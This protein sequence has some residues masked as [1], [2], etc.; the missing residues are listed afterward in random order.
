MAQFFIGD[1]HGCAT[2]LAELLERLAPEPGDQVF[3]TGDILDRGPDPLGV[4]DLVRERNLL[5]IQSNH[6][7][8]LARV[9]R[10]ED[11]RGMRPPCLPYIAACLD[12]CAARR[13][14]LAAFLEALPWYRQG[15]GWLMVHAGIHPREGLAGTTPKMM[16]TMRRWPD[17]RPA[18]P[19]WYEHYQ[20]ETLVIFGHNARKEAVLHRVG[21]RLVAAG[22][23]T[24]CVYGGSLTALHLEEERL[25]QVPARRDYLK[26]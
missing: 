26:D 25:V 7:L 21:E 18:D 13:S 23:D 24:G 4:L 20:G 15:P 5:S 10:E 19:P 9:L 14:E 11:E 8:H 17:E 22:L 3:L 6:E 2:E 1:V 16:V 12:R